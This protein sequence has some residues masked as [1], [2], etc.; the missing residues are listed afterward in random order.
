VLVAGSAVYRADEPAEAVRRLRGLA[1]AAHA[2][3]WWGQ[4]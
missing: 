4:S 1:D 2:K 3:S